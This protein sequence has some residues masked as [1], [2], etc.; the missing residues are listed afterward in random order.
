MQKITA[1][2][3]GLITGILMACFAYSLYYVKEPSDSGLQYIAYAIYAAGIIWT[4][5]AYR[6]SPAFTGKFGGLFGQGFRCFITVTLIMVVFT[7]VFT[8]MHPE[9]ADEAAQNY[10]KELVEKKDKTPAE[11][12]EIITKVKKQYAI[13]LI[14]ISIFGYLIVGSAITAAASA[15]LIKRQV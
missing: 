6:N 9:F 13:Q 10:R 11:I 14:S 3:K 5:L 8:A 2:V 12:D 7:G 1:P 4:L 15:L